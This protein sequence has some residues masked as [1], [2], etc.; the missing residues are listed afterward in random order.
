MRRSSES[1]RQ[2]N[3][4]LAQQELQAAH[5]G[6][7]E[8]MRQA[9]AACSEASVAS[10]ADVVEKN[11]M[12]GEK[13]VLLV[14]ECRGKTRKTSRRTGCEHD[15]DAGCK[16]SVQSQVQELRGAMCETS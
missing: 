11:Q 10:D 13:P 14:A 8:A 9:L 6:P 16:Q 2:E 5:E 1:L 4:R 15:D 7:D 12:G 3:D